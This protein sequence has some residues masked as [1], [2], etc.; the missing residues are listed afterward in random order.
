MLGFLADGLL[1]GQRLVYLAGQ[2]RSSALADLAGL[3]DLDELLD[4]GV[5]QVDPLDG[6]SARG[7]RPTSRRS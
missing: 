5:L 3:G 7:R 6:A 4:R 1:A 2:A